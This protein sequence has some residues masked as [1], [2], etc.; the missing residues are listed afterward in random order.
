MP[1]NEPADKPAPDPPHQPPLPPLLDYP[2][3]PPPP[4]PETERWSDVLRASLIVFGSLAVLFF[5]IFGL[6]GL[7]GRGC[8]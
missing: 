8:G 7:M 2:T 5:G 1:N 4:E 3:P 6:C